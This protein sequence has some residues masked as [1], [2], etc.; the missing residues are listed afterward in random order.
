MFGK[1]HEDHPE[2]ATIPPS[3]PADHPG[4]ATT[5]VGATRT[6]AEA[7]TITLTPTDISE[8]MRNRFFLLG[9]G[10]GV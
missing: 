7:A 5:P 6:Q 1:Q 2:H 3:P 9:G 10:G 4:E 8:L